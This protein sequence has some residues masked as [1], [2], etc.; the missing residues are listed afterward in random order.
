MR[1]V[2]TLTLAQALAACGT[3]MLVTFGGIVGARLA[4]SPALATLPWS[5]SIV[6]LAAASIPAALL[7]QRHGR[8]RVLI[9]SALFGCVAAL[10][11]AFSISQGSF[12]GLCLSASLFGV[13]ASVVQQYR[14]AATELV[15]Q[16]A[17]AE[18]TEVEAITVIGSQIKGAKIDTALPVTLVSEDDVVATGAV[19]G[20]ELFRAI[21]QAGDV[22]FQEA[23][24]TGNLNTARTCTYH[25]HNLPAN[26]GLKGTIIIQ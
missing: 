8:R 12:I 23:R 5:L 16:D 19:S 21:P 7:M 25:D 14:F 1:H 17:G 24:T 6:G 26:A 22:Q 11:C 10:A 18:G 9:A 3:I 20:D 15:S 13:H 2:W 4:P